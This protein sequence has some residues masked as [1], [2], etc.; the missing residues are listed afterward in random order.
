MLSRRSSDHGRGRRRRGR[1]SGIIEPPEPAQVRGPTR[2]TQPPLP[3][4]QFRVARPMMP[5]TQF[6]FWMWSAC[7]VAPGSC[8]WLV[9]PQSVPAAASVRFPDVSNTARL[10]HALA[11]MST[12]TRLRPVGVFNVGFLGLSA[13]TALGCLLQTPPLPSSL[14]FLALPHAAS[15]S[16]RR[17]SRSATRSQRCG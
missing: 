3:R 10:F 17:S 8:Q 6:R 4:R 15:T 11:I 9:G 5:T 2:L 7:T 12:S 1:V 16:T 14:S 13:A